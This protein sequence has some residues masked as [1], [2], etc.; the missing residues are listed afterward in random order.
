MQKYRRIFAEVYDKKWAF[1]SKQIAPKILSFY[2]TKNIA[3][4]NKSLL[5]LCCGTGQL[6]LFFLEH[7]YRTIGI[8]KSIHMLNLAREKNKK[9]LNEGLVSFIEMDVCKFTLKEHFGLIVSTYDS[10]NHLD[11]TRKLYSCF[12][13]TYDVLTDG[14]YF[15]FDLN[16]LKSLKRWSSFSYRDD[17]EIF[18]V[19]NGI[20]LE[21]KKK[22]Y[23]HIT[24]FIKRKEN[25]HEKFNEVFYN[26]AF[27]LH[28]VKAKLLSCGFSDVYFA[29]I[30]NLDESLKDPEEEGRVFIIAKK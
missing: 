22:G 1:F 30:K 15:I 11:S 28:K 19:Q 16:T 21:D 26:T 14:G 6:C 7:G 24:G 29:N 4:N 18:L 13:S 25:L 2:E 20:F 8:D 5:D 23:T 17:E 10:L 3:K 27:N 9:Y 12:S